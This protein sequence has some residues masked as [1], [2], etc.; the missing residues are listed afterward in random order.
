MLDRLDPTG[1]LSLRQLASALT[2]E[3]LPTPAG[4]AVWTAGQVARVKARLPRDV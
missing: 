3:G 1:S 2:A 4:A